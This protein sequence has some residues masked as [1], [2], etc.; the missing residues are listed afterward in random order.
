MQGYIILFC[1]NCASL[2]VVIF[3]SAK[4]ATALVE[5]SRWKPLRY[6]N[7]EYGFPI[8]KKFHI[9]DEYEICNPGDIVMFKH[10]NQHFSKIKKFGLVEVIRAA[11]IWQDYP[12]WEGTTEGDF[13]IAHS[14]D[15]DR[16]DIESHQQRLMKA[17]Y[18]SK[19]RKNIFAKNE[20]IKRRDRFNRKQAM[21][22]NDQKLNSFR[23]QV[24][25]WGV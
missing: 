3:R 9:H 17:A 11:P 7:T 16:D 25:Q 21:K 2:V 19:Q 23:D 14:S 15:P 20:K 22:I 24:S 8:T 5:T 18:E 10:V 13:H 12:A 4:T 6:R 1:Y